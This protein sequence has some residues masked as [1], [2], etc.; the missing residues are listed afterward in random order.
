MG[1][2]E[3]SI[4]GVFALLA[5]LVGAAMIYEYWWSEGR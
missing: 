3:K 5:G 1:K 4:A 2:T